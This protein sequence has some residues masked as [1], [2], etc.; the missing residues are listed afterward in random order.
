MSSRNNHPFQIRLNLNREHSRLITGLSDWLERDLLS[1]SQVTLTITRNAVH[2][3]LLLGLEAW[4]QEGLVDEATVK[5]LCRNLSCPLP[6]PEIATPSQP[7]PVAISSAREVRLPQPKSP[8][9]LQQRWESLQAELSLQWLLFLGVFMVVVSSGVLA[10]SQWQ[11]FPPAGQYSVL[12]AYTLCFWGVSVWAT[13]QGNLPLTARTLGIVA[14]LLLPVNFWAMDGFRLAN[15]LLGIGVSLVAILLLSLLTLNIGK[16]RQQLA[17]FS[18]SYLALSCLHWGWGIVN[19]PVIAVY[20]GVGI[21]IGLF[22]WRRDKL[23]KFSLLFYS[24]GVL[25]FRALFVAGV[26]ISQLGLAIGASGALFWWE[27]ETRFQRRLGGLCLFIGW[28]VAFWESVPWQALIL[29]FLGLVIVWR[30]LR[31]FWRYVDFVVILLIV[32]QMFDLGWR[33]IP[34]TIQSQLITTAINLTQAEANPNTLWAI[35]GFGYVIFLV[36]FSDWLHRQDKSNLGYRGEFLALI[37]AI[38][39]I[40][41]SFVNPILRTIIFLNCAINLAIISQRRQQLFALKRG[42]SRSDLQLLIYWHHLAIIGTFLSGIDLI[43]A[44][45]G[46]LNW[47]IVLLVLAVAELIFSLVIFQPHQSLIWRNSAWYFGLGL[48]TCS[49]ILFVAELSFWCLLWLVI[50]LTLTFVASQNWRLRCRVSVALSS[51]GLVA[52]QPILL[53]LAISFYAADVMLFS[54]GFAA[55]VMLVNTSL[56]NSILVKNESFSRGGDFF[57]TNLRLSNRETAQQLLSA[58]ITVGFLLGFLVV[59]IAK[60]MTFGEVYFLIVSLLIFGLWGLRYLLLRQEQILA[61]LYGKGIDSWA[62]LL[63]SL[64]LIWLTLHSFLVYWELADADVVM[65]GSGIITLGAI[66]FRSLTQRSVWGIYALGWNVEI[67]LAEA[68]GLLDSELINLAIANLSLGLAVQLFGDWWKLRQQTNLSR[69]WQIIPLLYGSL[70][71]ALRWGTFTRWTGLLT[72]ALAIIVIGVG[73]RKEAFKPLVYLALVGVTISAYEALFYQF[74]LSETGAIGDGF[75]L[76]SALGTAIAYAYLLL[77]PWLRRYLCLTRQEL[78]FFAHLHWLGSSFLLITASFEEIQL[79][80]TIGLT[81]GALLVQYAW[82][83][84]RNHPQAKIGEAWVYA[85]FIEALGLRLYWLSLP[86][87]QM[88]ASLVIWK[89]AIASAFA[90]FLYILPWQRWG[91]SKRPWQNIALLIPLIA[92]LENPHNN[93]F[94]SYLFVAAFYFI[95]TVIQNQIRYTYISILI[96]IWLGFQQAANYNLSDP[97]WY[98]APISLAIL[99]FAQFDP[100]FQSRNQRQTRHYLRSFSIGIIC[101]FAFIGHLEN[102]IFPGII[103]LIIILVGL[104]F[105]IRAFLYIGTITFLLNAT[106]QLVIL[107]FEYPFSK[108][109]VGLLVGISLI[110]LAATFETRR[111][112]IANLVRSWLGELHDWE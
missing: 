25:L 77:S 51:F 97:L 83:Q 47:A 59:I 41:I 54:F 33:L 107:I 9:W 76:M 48:A 2:P 39:L 98:I 57:A 30:R 111:E 95:P 46:Y 99:Y 5:Q 34:V 3:E 12:L 20:L 45:L 87:A 80:M 40:V 26:A 8:S 108:W 14:L 22:L 13:R 11:N 96:L 32:G 109:I 63:W 56:L 17:I 86:L 69:H 106:Y 103:S 61:K 37:L 104:G 6:Q 75:I 52:I 71:A 29:S 70:G 110:W 38:G 18:S 42:F 15:N 16:R 44:N 49:Y 58:I 101:F 84:G 72:L 1:N 92:L 79:A 85:G 90:Y 53:G 28:F 50:P 66:A 60:Y 100:I 112:Q 36:G 73:R 91:W 89:G 19:F 10:A 94:L 82:L 93:H 62:I 21:I 81:T 105:K 23:V 55:G 78:N 74:S 4:L 7:Q 35:V 64:A 65:L 43:F 68:V 24:Q 88:L 27:G 67:I 102:G 31:R